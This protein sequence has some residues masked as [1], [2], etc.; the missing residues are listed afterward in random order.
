MPKSLMVGL[1]VLGAVCVASRAG[2]CVTFYEHA[3]YAGRSH[4]APAGRNAWF[5]PGMGDWV[6][7]MVLDPG[8]AVTV[9]EHGNFAG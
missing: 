9:Y 5:T 1:L 4:H 8:C 2:A 6:S 7:S 3:N